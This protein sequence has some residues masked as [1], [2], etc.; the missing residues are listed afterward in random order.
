MTMKKTWLALAA[1]TAVSLLH[2]ETLKVHKLTPQF[3][4]LVSVPFGY[5]AD[6]PEPKRWLEFLGRENNQNLLASGG[7][8]FTAGSIEPRDDALVFMDGQKIVR[9]ED[10]EQLAPRPKR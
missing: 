2:A 9:L 5:D 8:P 6:A 10:L 7:I 3:F 4:G 1:C